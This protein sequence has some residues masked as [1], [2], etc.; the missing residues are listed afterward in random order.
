MDDSVGQLAVGT[1]SLGLTSAEAGRRL[2]EFG[3]NVVV[4]K[5]PHLVWELISKFWA[6][7]PWML[8]TTI[9]L[10]LALGKALEAGVIGMLLIFNASLSLF[11]EARARS[12]LEL[13]QKRLRV[14]ARVRRDGV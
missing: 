3:P 13:L 4:E 10:E 2:V 14:R 1:A 7:V 5:R 12:A 11:Q 8:E 6:P 9:V